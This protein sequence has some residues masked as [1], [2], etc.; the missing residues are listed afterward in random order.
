[1][2][3]L[4][5][6]AKSE[7]NLEQKRTK[8]EAGKNYPCGYGEHN[9]VQNTGNTSEKVSKCQPDI[10]H[11]LGRQKFGSKL[12]AFWSGSALKLTAFIWN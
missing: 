8:K 1:M 4:F 3:N 11:L 7:Q 9:T 12:L 6:E 2:Q 10:V 5:Q